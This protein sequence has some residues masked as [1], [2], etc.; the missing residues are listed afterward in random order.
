MFILKEIFFS[1]TSRLNSVK[2]GIN[3]A[4]VKGILNCSNKGP[5]PLQRGDDHETLV[6]SLNFPLRTTEPE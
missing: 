4:W 2:L 3:H 5:G 1:R 6:R